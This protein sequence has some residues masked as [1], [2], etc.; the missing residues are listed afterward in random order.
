MLS[1][2]D[3]CGYLA[4]DQ[5]EAS[6]RAVSKASHLRKQASI[7]QR[8]EEI[9]G[10]LTLD[11]HLGVNQVVASREMGHSH[12]EGAAPANGFQQRRGVLRNG[13]TTIWWTE[14]A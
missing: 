5:E 10:R 7:D 3:R 9:F 14:G 1:E 13:P 6:I 4:F 2:R 12:L 8:G 11:K